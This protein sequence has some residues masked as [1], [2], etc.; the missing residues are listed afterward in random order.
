L[1]I[2]SFFLPSPTLQVI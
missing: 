2:D 1:K